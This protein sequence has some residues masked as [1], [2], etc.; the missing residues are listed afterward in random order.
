M[1]SLELANQIAEIIVDKQ[2]EDI[3]LLDLREVTTFTDYFIISSGTSNRHLNA[4]QN[5]IREGLKKQDSRV[6][7]QS[8]EGNAETGW[9]LMDFSSVIVHLFT[10]ETRT[11][12]DLESL[13][14]SGRT[15]TRIQ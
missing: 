11:Y 6:L 10:P 7:A 14:K 13:W 15:I 9:V 3:L 4:L 5:A 1:E 2:G 8:V 12:Y